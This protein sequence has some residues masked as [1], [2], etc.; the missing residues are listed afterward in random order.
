VDVLDLFFGLVYFVAGGDGEIVVVAIV[1]GG[2]SGGGDADAKGPHC[3]LMIS[4]VGL[5]PTHH[6]KAKRQG[7][8][9]PLLRVVIFALVISGLSPQQAIGPVVLG[10]RHVNEI[11]V[12]E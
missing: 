10:S 3:R 11:E 12:E 1:N 2:S 7:I 8:V 9:N 5:G 6:P 4:M